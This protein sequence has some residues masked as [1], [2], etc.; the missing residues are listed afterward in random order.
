M[1]D[2]EK[3]KKRLDCSGL[4]C[5]LPLIKARAQLDNMKA[6]EKLEVIATC[7]S[8]EKDIEIL[9]SLKHFELVRKWKENNRFRFLIKKLS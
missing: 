6:G 3:S 1:I 2:E 7:S 5:S 9:T 4:S 8:A